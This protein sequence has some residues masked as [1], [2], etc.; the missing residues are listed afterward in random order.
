[1]N[2]IEETIAKDNKTSRPI[3]G[4]AYKNDIEESGND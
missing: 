2:K 3:I 1:L 4:A